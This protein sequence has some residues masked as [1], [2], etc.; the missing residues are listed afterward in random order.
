[1]PPHLL[2]ERALALVPDC[3]DF[4]PLRDAVIG[5]SRVD[6]GKIWD[7]SSA[8]AT[9]GKR[10]VDADL[11]EALVPRVVERARERL[12]ELFSLVAT[13]IRQQQDGDSAGAVLSLVRAGELEEGERRLDRAEAIYAM[14]LEVAADL[15]DRAPQIL[16]LRRLGR[17]LR[18]AGRLDDA[19]GWYERSYEMAFDQGDV[20]GQAI[21]CQGLGNLCDDRGHREHSRMWNERG[22]R[23]AGGLDDPSL[24]WPFLNNLAVL[25]MLRG[26]LDEADEL[27]GR[28]RSRIEDAG[29]EGALAFWDNNRGL[30]LTE[31]GKPA[32]AEEAFRAALGRGPEAWWEMTIRV[33]LGHALV[34]LDRLFEAEEEARRAEELAIVGRFIPDLVDVYDLLGA[35]AASRCDEEGFV[36]YEQALRVCRERDLPARIAASVHHGY[37][38]LHAACGRPAEARAYLELAHEAYDDLGMAPE[39]DRV[40]ADLH[41]LGEVPAAV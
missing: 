39:A 9:L 8:Y 33:N 40:G 3:E 10:L 6:R 26:D 35:I 41:S 27:L 19:W 2:V 16:V 12:Q 18:A 5:T 22:L 7:R 25:A 17:T 28:A 29:D 31:S 4:L 11:L 32:A 37:G 38:R 34:K 23:L 24:E 13:A 20:P 14:A 36:F 21:A 15:R 1:M 30:L